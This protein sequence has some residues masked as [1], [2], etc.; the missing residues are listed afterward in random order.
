MTLLD[1][2]APARPELPTPVRLDAVRVLA[3]LLLAHLTGGITPD[4]E[5]RDELEDHA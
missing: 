2:D 4:G 5:E 3:E 1:H